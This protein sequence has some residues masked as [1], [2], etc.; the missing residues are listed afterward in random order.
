MT[1]K[2]VEHSVTFTDIKYSGTQDSMSWFAF[3]KDE[4]DPRC[5]HPVSKSVIKKIEY[6][7]FVTYIGWMV[8]FVIC[9]R[10]ILFWGSVG[11]CCAAPISRSRSSSVYLVAGPDWIL[12]LYMFLIR[13][14][15]RH[16]EHMQTPQA[17][18]TWELDQDHLAVSHSPYNNRGLL[19]WNHTS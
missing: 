7:L 8:K 1:R 5:T 16:R 6:A 2:R 9:I 4:S 12:T 18:P 15:Q 10:P 13:K 11:S 17:S 19:K 14:P 3:W